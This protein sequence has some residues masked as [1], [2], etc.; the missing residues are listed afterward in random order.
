M[1]RS[2]EVCFSQFEFESIPRPRLGMSR[3]FA[4][5]R[6]A[7]DSV[8]CAEGSKVHSVA[9]CASGDNEDLRA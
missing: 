4:I 7:V 2:I 1:L 5:I 8:Y 3:C 6:H 9:S